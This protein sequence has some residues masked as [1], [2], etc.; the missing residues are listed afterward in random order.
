[1]KNLLFINFLS[2]EVF[3][4]LFVVIVSCTK[5]T[6]DENNS[7]ISTTSI[8]EIY[9]LENLDDPRGYCIDIKGSKTD[10]NINQPLQAH[11]CYSYQG[12][13]SV[14]QGFDEFK[15]LNNEFIIPFFDVCMEIK[16]LSESSQIILNPCNNN[17]K[18]KFILDNVGKIYPEGDKGLC[19]TI[20]E[21]YQEGGGAVSYTHLT[22]PT[23]VGV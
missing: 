6:S 14:D 11:T 23:I 9:L 5:G 12:Q 19:L 17:I 8:V 16:S 21:T 7:T 20:S 22:L 3:L 1:M 10:A 2:S 15:I 13:V 4:L 18:Q